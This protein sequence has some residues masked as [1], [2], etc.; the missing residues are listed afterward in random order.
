MLRLKPKV[1]P[2]PDNIAAIATAPGRGGIGVVRVSGRQLS[3]LAIAIIG[4]FPPSRKAVYTPFLDQNG[5]IIDRGI[6]LYFPAPHSYTGED[7]LELQGHGGTAVLQ[8][9]LQRCLELGA[10]LALPG[11]FTQRAYLN[12]K[13][14]LAQAESVADL[15]EAT[16]A[17]AAKSA[18][19]SLIGDFSRVVH[20]LVSQLID[21]RMLVEAMLDFPEEEL[22][23]PDISRRLLKLETIRIELQ[24]TLNIAQQGSL[25]RE[26]AHIV[27]I[28]QPNV[29]KSSLLNCL[30][31]E[32]IALVSDV[33]GTTR[34]LIRQTIQINGIP[35]HI[36]DT[37]GL[38]D[39]QDTVELMGIARTQSTIQKADAILLM[40]DAKHGLS[41]ADKKILSD[42]P[43]NT[44]RLYIYNKIDLV[45]N[46]SE[47]K[48][49]AQDDF[50]Y[51]SAKT[52]AGIDLLREKLL[53]LIGWHQEAGVFMARERHIR[54]LL[55]AQEHLNKALAELSRSEFFAEELRLAQQALNE[56]TG[57][58]SPDDL[59]G[60]IFSRFCIG[61]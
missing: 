33:P 42:L 18:M 48:N 27:L 20:E 14:D 13:L 52:G 56:I 46:I 50:L 29:G 38:R 37:A 5:E 40:L 41:E 11:E 57:E 30:S 25:L 26:G 54:A 10:R 28:G 21:L 1:L 32:E 23:T 39:S 58:F 45:E 31:G 53:S 51:I 60:E 59:L 6:A 12:E 43:P 34:D 44:P 4:F 17:Q 19:R 49:Q 3:D 35:L 7:I 22:E 16:T 9:L 24:R 2:K 47:F 55:L 15:I 61:K 36:I 8:L